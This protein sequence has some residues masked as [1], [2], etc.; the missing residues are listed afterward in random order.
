LKSFHCTSEF[1]GVTLSFQAAFSKRSWPYFLAVTLPWLVYQGQ[2]TVRALRR[3]CA[4]VRHEASFYRF[5]SDFKVRVDVFQRRLFDL[6]VSTFALT[7]LVI[8]VDDT[9]CPKWG[10]KIFGTG[11]F[12]DH[13]S[14]PKPGFI[15]G[16]NWVVLAIV[17]PLLGSHVALPFWIA[18]YRTKERCEPSAFRTRHELVIEALRAARSWTSLPI[19]LLA[20]GAYNNESILT[21]LRELGI[22]LVSRLRVDARLRAAPPK[23][24]RNRRGRR[25]K[26]GKAFPRLAG[27]RRSNR[28]WRRVNVHIYGK[29]V[30]LDIKTFLAWWPTAAQ[31]LRVVITRDPR[32]QRKGAILSSTDTSQQAKDIVELFARR[33]SIEQL[34][35]DAKQTLGLDSAEVRSERSV[36][37]HAILAFGFLTMVR[38]W[39]RNTMNS[40]RRQPKSFAGQLSALREQI[41]ETTIFEESPLTHGSRSYAKSIAKLVLSKVPA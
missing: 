27:M 14:R 10:R 7:E 4:L 5:F 15:W 26:Y 8:V 32:H 9:L 29:D 33:W 37:R 13:V 18:L 39:A 34:F 6:V 2:R 25:P 28:G 31:Y 17:V 22:P 12:F 3:G 40:P 35:A 24:R 20:D 11:R 23:R 16:H 21:P 38:V 41:I 19:Q 36:V 1:L 30:S